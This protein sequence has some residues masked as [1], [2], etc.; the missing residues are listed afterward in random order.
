MIE[1]EQ[2]ISY[3]DARYTYAYEGHYKILPAIH[4]WDGDSAR[5][6]DGQLVAPDFN[7]CSDTNPEWMTKEQLQNWIDKNREKIGMV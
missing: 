3:E 1:H 2:K 4:N 6:G 7:Y 5:I